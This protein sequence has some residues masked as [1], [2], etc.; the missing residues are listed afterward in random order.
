VRAIVT[1]A[2]MLGFAR[3]WPC[4]NFPEDLGVC[5]EFDSNGNLVDIE[6]FNAWSG[7]RTHEPIGID[8]RALLAVSEDAQNG[9]LGTRV[10]S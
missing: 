1:S 7:K 8:E 6:W 9:L 3:R 4:A 2:E 5:F 10:Q